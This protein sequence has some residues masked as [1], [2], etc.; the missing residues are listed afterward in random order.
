MLNKSTK[1]SHPSPGP[2]WINFLLNSPV[3][4]L[5]SGSRTASR[6]P[7]SL[8]SACGYI[9]FKSQTLEG[10]SDR[11]N[12]VFLMALVIQ[13]IRHWL[14]SLRLRLHSLCLKEGWEVTLLRFSV[15][16]ADRLVPSA[17]RSHSLTSQASTGSFIA[18]LKVS[19]IPE[20]QA[21]NIP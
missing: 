4:I 10:T 12:Q 16:T 7:R 2:C 14:P 15:S 11:D 1:P 13:S 8:T 18:C 20:A 3:I 5:L 9:V 6:V 17:P 19:P 21:P